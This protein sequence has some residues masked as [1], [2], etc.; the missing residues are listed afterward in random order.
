MQ[1]CLQNFFCK[2]M[3][4]H[5]PKAKKNLSEIWLFSISLDVYKKHLQEQPSRVFWKYAANLQENIHAELWFQ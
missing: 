1:K 5:E 2:A 4:L 3:M